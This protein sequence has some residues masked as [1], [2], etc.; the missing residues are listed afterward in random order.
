[1]AYSD[2]CFVDGDY[3]QHIVELDVG[4]LNQPKDIVTQVESQSP[5]V[6]IAAVQVSTSSVF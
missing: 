2:I 6:E 5:V 1:M 4:T 3:Q